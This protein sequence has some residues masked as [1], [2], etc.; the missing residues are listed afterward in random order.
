MNISAVCQRSTLA[1]NPD[2]LRKEALRA[3][4]EITYQITGGTG[5]ASEYT[6]SFDEKFNLIPESVEGEPW[7]KLENHQCPNCPYTREQLEYC[8]VALAISQVLFS[9]EDAASTENVHCEVITRERRFSAEVDYQK[10]IYS[11]L[12]LLMATSGCS[13]FSFLRPAARLHLPFATL[14]ETVTRNISFY[15]LAQYFRNPDISLKQGLDLLTEQFAELEQVN[16]ALIERVR[17]RLMQGDVHSNAMVV[18]SSFS[19]VL[20]MDPE[21]ASGLVS[22][23]FHT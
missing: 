15:L 21:L 9:V 20:S 10:A 1:G 4:H 8:P 16:R 14:Q 17:S 11:I 19:Q 18:L 22:D 7:T 3:E 23:M 12:G 6:I 5:K 2:Q 13:R